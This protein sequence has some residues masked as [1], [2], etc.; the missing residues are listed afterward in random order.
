MSLAK[1]VS[2]IKEKGVARKSLFLIEIPIPELLRQ[3]LV[4]NGIDPSV[5]N[6]VHLYCT[7]VIFPDAS[8]MTTEAHTYGPDRH[9]PYEKSTSRSSGAPFVFNMDADLAIKSFFDLWIREWSAGDYGWLMSWYDELKT[10]V[11]IYQLDNTG[12]AVYAVILY[13]A[14]PKATTELQGSSG[15]DTVHSL[16]VDFSYH[17]WDRLNTF[18][19]PDPEG[20]NPSNDAPTNAPKDNTNFGI[21]KGSGGLFGAIDKLIGVG[22]KFG[23]LLATAKQIKSKGMSSLINAGSMASIRSVTSFKF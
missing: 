17:Y 16:T 22:R 19:Q 8:V 12:K 18:P 9:I 10:E 5:I 2:E 23:G 3:S 6:T 1:F 14:F 13:D 7:D 21:P 4:L 20:I 15:D 11:T